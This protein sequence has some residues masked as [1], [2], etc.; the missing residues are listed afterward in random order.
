MS[1]D[2][3][4]DEHSRGRTNRAEARLVRSI[5][6]TQ[7]SGIIPETPNV[8]RQSD[9]AVQ[10]SPSMYSFDTSA[11]DTKPYPHRA[12]PSFFVT[13]PSRRLGHGPGSTDDPSGIQNHVKGLYNDKSMQNS[14]VQFD[15]QIHE[16][17][18]RKWFVLYPDQS[19][20]T[21]WDMYMLILLVY[22]ALV[23]VYVYSFLGIL[24]PNSVWFWIERYLDVSF[25]ADIVII[26][27]TAYEKSDGTFE[28]DRKKIRYRYLRSWFTVDLIATIP[29]DIVAL[30]VY[31][32]STEQGPSILLLPRYMR[33]LRLAK[34]F[35]VVKLLRINRKFTDLEV[36]LRI[37][38]GYLR[39][40]SLFAT[41]VL[42]AHWFACLFYYFGFIT[43]GTCATGEDCQYPTWFLKD[44][45]DIPADNFGRYIAALY[46]SVYTITTIGYGD[47]VPETTA[48]RSY[49]IIIMLCGA[50]MF[51]YVISQV[52]DIQNELKESSVYHRK[53]MDRLTDL[54]KSRN[55]PLELQREI[56]M[57]FER[58]YRRQRVVDEKNLFENI[59][60]DELRFRVLEHIYGDHVRKSRLLKYISSAQLSQLYQHMEEKEAQKGEVVYK[61]GDSP[62]YFYVVKSGAVAVRTG[63]Q[64][65]LFKEGEYFGD[66]GL[67]FGRPRERV[68]ICE[69]DTKLIVVPRDAVMKTLNNNE[70]A[71]K[72]VKNEEAMELWSRVIGLMEGEMRFAKMARLLRDRG[73]EYMI[74]KGVRIPRRG[75]PGREVDGVLQHSASEYLV[76]PHGRRG[77]RLAALVP[78]MSLS[79][80][81]GRIVRDGDVLDRELSDNGSMIVEVKEAVGEEELK[82]QLVEKCIE[83]R[84]LQGRL[85][86]LQ[87]RVSMVYGQFGDVL[88]VLN[89]AQPQ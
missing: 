59:R 45:G 84:E 10:S 17:T 53:Q 19:L 76:R 26:F 50:A 85:N 21:G 8:D 55:I 86:E 41:V 47:V 89:E 66:E 22:V 30:G 11:D 56:R 12:W 78:R 25:L 33:L 60:S 9:R 73:E 16:E 39:L 42:A 65:Q 87:S 58:E 75:R 28:T 15:G 27:C 32:N 43:S 13:S 4:E 54:A 69:E 35:H 79:N 57:D 49:T 44:A 51:A 24:R 70:K 6:V 63:K 71:L 31:R 64:E 34:L 23:S 61:K 67:F 36:Q 40:A 3:D 82:R 80:Q 77:G 5:L 72:R 62:N 2:G 14:P 7:H 88:N 46:F 1:Q 81:T 29:W 68:A 37:K 48:E 20:K 83:V 18:A 52:S 38:Y 74:S